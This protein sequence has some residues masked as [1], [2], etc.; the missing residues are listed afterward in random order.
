MFMY[1]TKI[2]CPSVRCTKLYNINAYLAIIMPM[3]KVDLGGMNFMF[4]HLLP[5]GTTYKLYLCMAHAYFFFFQRSFF[6]PPD[7][8]RSKEISH[9]D[10]FRLFQLIYIHTL[11]G[12]M[13]LIFQTF[14]TTWKNQLKKILLQFVKQ[15]W[16]EKIYNPHFCIQQSTFLKYELNW[17]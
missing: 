17:K 11:A 3:S 8:F 2:C 5:N 15:T 4:W 16:R 13:I 9:R 14:Q 12:N 7:F 6:Y 1:F 10:I